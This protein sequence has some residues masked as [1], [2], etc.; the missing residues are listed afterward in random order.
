MVAIV[1]TTGCLNALKASARNLYTVLSRQVGGTCVGG[2]GAWGE[3]PA[4][5]KE[6][7]LEYELV[8]TNDPDEEP[9]VV[10]VDGAMVEAVLAREVVDALGEGQDTGAGAVPNGVIWN[11]CDCDLCSTRENALEI[12]SLA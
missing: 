12:V 6:S 7:M 9:L 5:R 4:V 8:P 11:A 1:I 3:V 10:L 2:F